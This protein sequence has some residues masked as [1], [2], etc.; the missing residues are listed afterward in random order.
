M[1]KVVILQ[2]YVPQYRVPFFQMLRAKGLT[3]GLDIRVAF[4]SV[5]ADQALRRDAAS[6][7]FG[8]P[9]EQ[10]EYKVAG[11]RMVVRRIAEAV[12]GSDLVIMEQARRNLDAYTML[13][14]RKRNGPLVALWGHGRDYTRPTSAVDRWVSRWLT[15]KA[16]WF[17]AYTAGG[18]NAVVAAGFPG[19]RTTVVQNAI[20]SAALRQNLQDLNAQEASEF[21]EKHD[22]RGKTALY[23]GALDASKRIEFLV[24]AGKAVHAQE[25]DFR[26]LVAGDGP[27]RDTVEE[28]TSDI[29][30]VTYLGSLGGVDK[31]IALSSA[32]VLTIPGRVGLV[33]V[34][35]FAAGVPIITTSW[36]W[37]APE[38][39]Y[40]ESGINSLVSSN[41]PISFGTAVLSVVGNSEQLNVLRRGARNA[42]STYTIETMSTNFLNG[43]R[44]ALAL[45]RP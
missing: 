23:M 20:D 5:G 15:S 6:L 34:D 40:L 8:I 12:R 44:G 27:M 41:D 16:D 21:W 31:A 19:G 14:V 7:D 28:W 25:P 35:S 45:R 33:A 30:W 29:P 24:E 10:R 43:I 18:M 26:L 37:H 32:Q 11:R 4:G 36:P 3:F 1:Q 22:L 2:E 42:A 17:F 9:I 38:F 13:P 39:E